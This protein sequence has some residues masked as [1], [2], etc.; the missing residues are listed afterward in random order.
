VIS[1]EY[2]ALVVACAIAIGLARA[3]ALEVSSMEGR[4]L[5]FKTVS[6]GTVL[7]VLVAALLAPLAHAASGRARSPVRRTPRALTFVPG[8]VV[9]IA[10]DGVLDVSP[11]G[12]PTSRNATV[13]GVLS[14]FGAERGRSVGPARR[15]GPSRRERVW[16][17]T[18]T[19][20]GFDPVRAAAELRATGAVRAACPNYRFALFT[21]QPN[22]LFLIYQWYIDDSQFADVRLPLAWDVARGD[23]SVVI[24]I[25]DTGVDTSHPDLA[26]Q[27]WHNPGEIPGNGLDDDGNGLIDDV[28]GWDFGMWDNDPKPEYTPEYP[29]IDVG[30]H[31]TFCA[32][33]AAAATNNDDGIAGAGWNCR[34]MPLKVSRPDSG[35]VASAIAGAF[36][37]AVDQ[38][39]SVLSMSFG[40]PGDLGVPEF[41]QSLVDMATDSGTL[42]V[43]AAGNDGDSLL[44]YPAACDNVLAVGATDFN[45]ERASFSN[46]GPW[47]DIAAPGSYMFSTI[48]RNYDFT[49]LDSLI[50]VGFFG[51]DAV[52][53][54]MLGDGTSFACPL[55]AGI[56]GLVRAKYPGLTPQLV[57]QHM[58]ATGDA[59]VYDEPI[60]PK[61][62]AFSAVSSVP[63]AVA[64]AERPPSVE[65]VRAAPNPVVGSGAI[66]F[67][68][69]R[70][71]S[72]RLSIYDA[73]GRLVRVLVRGVFTAGP[74]VAPWDGRSDVGVRLP[75]AVYFARLESGSATVTTKV[76]LMPQP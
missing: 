53:P 55:V 25:M 60:G 29:G 8:E 15:P 4:P 47:V 75:A 51:W 23:P 49:P 66:R 54:Y 9:V 70:G 57:I 24:A 58:V 21:T 37:Y 48:C 22:D 42:C 1:V 40:G 27:I 16:V 28:E 74:H 7:L 43:A 32:G 12:A 26:S 35:L 44:V 73:S 18:S 14:R 69:A 19:R 31:G 20:P 62:N 41:F 39:A 45:N 10:D 68:L 11:D 56:C 38:G 59:V 34:I 71:G 33:I 17:L 61:V 6:A 50:Y 46:F 65:R 63:T 13:A 52:N 30:F 76:I 2:T 64:V 36:V 72:A 3:S 67:D 5:T